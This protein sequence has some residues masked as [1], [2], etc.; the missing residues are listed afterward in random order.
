MAGG[1]KSLKVRSP[2]LDE[3]SPMENSPLTAEVISFPNRLNLAPPEPISEKGSV[4]MEENRNSS[5][6]LMHD[7]EPDL[8]KSGKQGNESIESE[9][10]DNPFDCFLKKD[11]VKPKESREEGPPGE[12]SSS[13]MDSFLIE[14]VHSIKN[15][16]AS[17]YRATVLTMD[18]YDDVEI[19]KRSHTQV[20]EE[21]KNIDSVLNTLLNFINVNTPIIK[22]STLYVI[23]EEIL[24]ANDKQLRQKHIKIYKKYENDLPDTFIHPEQVRFIL[25]SA[26]QHA[27]LSTP[28]NEVIGFLMRSS[29]PNHGTGTEKNL[30]EDKRRYVE[31]MIGFDGGKPVDPSENLSGTPPGQSEG[32]AD[33]ILKLAK[34][35]LERNHGM[36][37]ET[38]KRSETILTLRFPVERRQVVYYEPIA[39]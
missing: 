15:G 19:R 36:M 26:L 38:R 17:V 10:E 22:T 6:G 12:Q 25:H 13:F 9:K 1:D 16:L 27:I 11:G 8:T 29:N 31:V 4:F 7:G 32:I 20:K 28:P 39:L 5:S 23:I 2:T 37:I 18:R 21:I 14:M 24:E 34:D 35:L 3:G 33:L 30:P